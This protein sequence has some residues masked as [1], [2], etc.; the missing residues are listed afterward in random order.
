M[1]QQASD[2]PKGV[3]YEKA[4]TFR[5]IPKSWTIERGKAADAKNVA[6]AIEWALLQQYHR[7]PDGKSGQW[8]K[9]WPNGYVQFSRS[10]IVTKDG[11]FSNVA[12]EQLIQAGIWQGDFGELKSSPPQV[13]CIVD[14]KVENYNNKP[15]AK[16]DWISPNADEPK[17]RGTGFA[18]ADAGLLGD[19]NARFRSA[20]R[21]IAG[22]SPSGAPAAPPAV[23]E[24]PKFDDVPDGP[25][26]T[27]KL[28]DDLPF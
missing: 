13:V 11:S 27:M 22:G 6:I 3:I 24:A 23:P 2:A 7:S 25:S 21:A 8:S 14:I 17:M 5:A 28:P 20:A 10:W 4:G 15:S 26:S 18:P 12:A 16:V 1:D 9:P 19:L